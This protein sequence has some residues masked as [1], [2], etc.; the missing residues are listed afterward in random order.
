MPRG[1]PKS[2]SQPCSPEVSTIIENLSSTGY[3][4]KVLTRLHVPSVRQDDITQDMFLSWL[5][6]PDSII[7]A[8]K[9]GY[10]TQYVLAACKNQ[11]SKIRLERI[12]ISIEDISYKI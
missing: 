6:N 4:Q 7:K 10:L 1:V 2:K 8:N 11:V 5:T 12:N 9:E 3:I